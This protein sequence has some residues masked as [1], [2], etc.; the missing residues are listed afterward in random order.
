MFRQFVQSG[1]FK[2]RVIFQT[3]NYS[4][5]LVVRLWILQ[6]FTIVKY[7]MSVQQ[8]MAVQTS[9]R[10]PDITIIGATLLAW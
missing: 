3:Q 6:V 5:L 2:S 7:S 4:D 9:E 8:L 1:T 10:P